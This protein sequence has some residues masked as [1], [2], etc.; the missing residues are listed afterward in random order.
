MTKPKYFKWWCGAKFEARLDP[1]DRK[2]LQYRQWF[3]KTWRPAGRVSHAIAFAFGANVHTRPQDQVTI[4]VRAPGGQFLVV[5]DHIERS[6][7][8]TMRVLRHLKVL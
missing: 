8:A 2:K 1:R 6:R 7:K 5:S 4:Q 3:Q